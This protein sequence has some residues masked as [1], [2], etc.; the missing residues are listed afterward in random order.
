MTEI[1]E[2]RG[3]RVP[4]EQGPGRVASRRRIVGAL[5][6]LEY[7]MRELF[8]LITVLVGWFVL[9]RVLAAVFGLRF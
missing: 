5:S 9:Q 7:D 2:P 8:A 4:A 3:G 6:W 1:P